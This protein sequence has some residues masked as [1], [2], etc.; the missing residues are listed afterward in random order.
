MTAPIA[1]LNESS[2]PAAIATREMQLELSYL[3]I[4]LA[5]D[6]NYLMSGCKY[7]NFVVKYAR[8]ADA[9]PTPSLLIEGELQAALFVEHCG[10]SDD[11]ADGAVIW[12][13][14]RCW[15]AKADA[16]NILRPEVAEQYRQAEFTRNQ[17]TELNKA[18]SRIAKNKSEDSFEAGFRVKVT[19]TLNDAG[20]Y[21]L[22]Q[23]TGSVEQ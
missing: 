13:M 3:P 15:K 19:Q 18:V 4:A 17:R 7:Q 9:N 1:C 2:S 10:F 20:A 8:F 22:A 5:L 21:Q 14:S 23:L 6:I 16:R 12:V 11:I